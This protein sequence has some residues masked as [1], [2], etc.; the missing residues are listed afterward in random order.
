MRTYLRRPSV[1]T[2]SL[3]VFVTGVLACEN[4]EGTSG[5]DT[6]AEIG[7]DATA[8]TPVEPKV[9]K[10]GVFTLV[11][12]SGTPFE[13]GQQ[14]GL[15]LHD[16]IEEAMAFVSS[17]PVL[18]AMPIAAENLGI[19]DM[20]RELSY[21]SLIEECEGLVDATADTGFNMELCLALNF[22]DILVEFLASGLPPKEIEGPGC[23]GAILT[24]AATSDGGLL[25]TRNLDWGSFNIDLLYHNPVLFLRQPAEGIPHVIVGF[26]LNLAPYSGMNL[27]GISIG[28]HEADPAS[29]KSQS[30]VGRS[31]VQMVG[32][33]LREAHSLTE[34]EAFLSTELG[35]T[36]E[37]LVIADGPSRDGAVFELTAR[38]LGVRPLVDGVVYA[39]NH[40]EHPDMLDLH[41][42]PSEGSLE[43]WKR[44]GQLLDPEGAD[45]TYG[46]VNLSSLAGV[47]RDTVDPR[48]GVSFTEEEMAEANWDTNVAL[49]VNAG[50]HFAIFDPARGLFYVNAGEPPLYDKAY[51]CFSLPAL[52]EIEGAETCGEIEIP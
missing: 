51:Q 16:V 37:S 6:G 4:D 5:A 46:G 15:L 3:L 29:A 18:S 43:R 21:P 25:H 32:E 2:L 7:E 35:M 13:M 36:T 42:E 27:A 41:E 33:M 44:L 50:M 45:S 9:E 10:R 38:N 47:M 22:G 8:W 24:G 28:S 31:H 40:F 12:L 14:H 52:L 30:R 26:P 1:L 19:L 17:D 48:R 34:V 49:G 23:S 11:W 20:A 39:T